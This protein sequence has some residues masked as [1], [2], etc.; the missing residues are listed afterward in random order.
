MKG[1]STLLRD[2][3]KKILKPEGERITIEGIFNH[4]W[5]KIKPKATPIPIDFTFLLKFS[6]FSKLK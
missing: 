5:M 2:L 6:K 1:I 3:L 4:P